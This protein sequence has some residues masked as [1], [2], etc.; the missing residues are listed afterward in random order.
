MS[1][2]VSQ[3]VSSSFVR[4]ATYLDGGDG[5]MIEVAR[6]KNGKRGAAVIWN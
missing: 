4:D 1:I 3:M 5:G 2:H 6:G